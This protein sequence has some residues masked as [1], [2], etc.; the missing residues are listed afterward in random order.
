MPVMQIAIDAHVHLYPFYDLRQALAYAL[1]NLEEAA[2]KAG[3]QARSLKA[4]LLAERHDCQIFKEL[5]QQTLQIAG[6]EQQLCTDLNALHYTTLLGDELFIIAGR[7]IVSAERL[8]ILSQFSANLI[9]DGLP[10]RE[11]IRTILGEGAKPVINWAPG[12]WFGQRGRLVEELMHEFGP[13]L[14]VC[15]T[16]LRPQGFAE[17]L[18]FKVA[19][20]LKIPILAGS[21]PF[22]FVSEEKRIGRYALYLED[23][24]DPEKPS[25]SL[26]QAFATSKKKIVGAR[27]SFGPVLSRVAKLML[28]GWH[29]V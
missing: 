2:L 13:K 8:E 11:V 27:L 18:L 1:K 19:H 3:C 21:D 28:F 10:A 24:F 6:F 9:A 4:L 17:P 23:G 20:E 25:V 7:Q 14:Y 26:A 12:K 5:K 15:D 29:P 16:A 22:P